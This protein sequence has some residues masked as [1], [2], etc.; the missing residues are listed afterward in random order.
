[1][2]ATPGANHRRSSPELLFT[3]PLTV[4]LEEAEKLHYKALGW[5]SGD[6]GSSPVF[7]PAYGV[8]V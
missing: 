1:M 5:E 2:P 6:P 3:L 4:V 8:N 7:A